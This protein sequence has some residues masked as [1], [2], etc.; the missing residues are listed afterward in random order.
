[1]ANL[2]VQKGSKSSLAVS[3]SFNLARTINLLGLGLLLSQSIG[4]APQG[5]FAQ[6]G[7]YRR[8]ASQQGKAGQIPEDA[9]KALESLPEK[10]ITLNLILG[11][12]MK[13]SDSFQMIT[14]GA[15][16]A[17]VSKT[18]ASGILNPQ[19]KFYGQAVDNQNEPQTSFQPTRL[20]SET[21]GVSVAKA[22]TSGT[23]LSFELKQGSFAYEFP[24]TLPVPAMGTQYTSEAKV[25]LRQNLWN[26]AFGSS[27]RKALEAADLQSQSVRATVEEGAEEW[28]NK[29]I[30]FY[31][32]VWLAQNSVRA[33]MLS[34]DRRNRLVEI[35]QTKLRRGT[36]ERPDFLQVESAQISSRIVLS[37]RRKALAEVWRNLVT[38]LRFPESWLAIDPLNVPMELD[39]PLPRAR[40]ICGQNN[41]L[42]QKP[43]ATATLKKLAL[44]DR[45]TQLNLEKSRDGLNPNLTLEVGYTANGLAPVASDGLDE[46]LAAR[47]PGWSAQLT[48][49]Y[50]L[51]NDG[52]KADY[53]AA[54][55][56]RQRVEAQKRQSEADLSVN[57][58]NQCSDLYRRIDEVEQRALAF[59]K[60]MERV[61]LEE[62]RFGF[63]RTPTMSVI[64]AGDDATMA[65]M[66]WLSA[67]ANAR[68]VAWGLM[69]LNGDLLKHLETLKE[70]ST[71]A[72]Q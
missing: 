13:S 71:M 6:D 17:D 24:P 16:A 70:K 27:T 39:D 32:N 9:R 37:E 20:N 58:L 48:L 19:L 42:A 29:L 14:A 59:K 23:A 52:A 49:S 63:G 11:A 66:E 4:L 15:I 55:S 65:E 60:Q 45:V 54:L 61:K 34:V 26:D 25:G 12:G 40:E 46:T 5:A 43:Q 7:K 22:F 3:N 44:Q 62:E 30:D 50:P 21:F 57:W 38:T 28:A 69:R 36:S 56:E 41:Y 18:K 72:A 8:V 68:R 2:L 10:K 53:L 1:M 31:Y 64:Q 35:T 47:H 67:Q 51:G 33:G